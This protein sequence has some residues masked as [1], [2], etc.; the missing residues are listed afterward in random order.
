MKK[1]QIAVLLTCYN[2]RE[3]TVKCLR[4]LYSNNLSDNYELEVFLVDDGSMDGTG[5]AVKKEFQE[6]FLIQGTGNLFWNRGMHLAW[7]TASKMSK[8]DYYLWL[9]D[10]VILFQDAI[11]DLL[12]IEESNK[13]SIVCGIMRSEKKE[14]VT[15]GGYDSNGEL[16]EPNGRTQICKG[17]FNGNLVL[18]ANSVFLK[19]G[20]L[21][22]I[23]IHAIGD[24]DYAMRAKKCGVQAYMVPRFSGICEKNKSLPQWCL[25]K[26]A[27]Y[28][29]LKSLY[30]PLGNAHPKYFF[31][32]EIR[33]FG[34]FR[35]VKHLIS[36]HLR[37]LVPSLW[38]H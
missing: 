1:K 29:R 34:I 23:F 16:I 33:H 38:K 18:V 9:N 31:L 32:Y 36:I 5:D 28:N 6:V 3:K 13:G 2:R 30:S 10:D 22:P 35:A 4:H 11:K 19:V 7:K 24:F 15:Y 37:V 12:E 25:P 26:V 14:E 27:L 21:D 17:A 20:N 8:Y